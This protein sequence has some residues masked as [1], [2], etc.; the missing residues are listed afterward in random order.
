MIYF[1]FLQQKKAPSPIIFISI[2]SET[3]RKFQQHAN[4]Q[5]GILSKY[6]GKSTYS[7]ESH[8]ENTES[9]Q[10]STFEGILIYFID[11]QLWKAFFLIEIMEFGSSRVSK[12]RQLEKASI[13]IILTLEGIDIDLRFLFSPNAISHIISVPSLIL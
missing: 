11:L 6:L 3:F 4:I 13:P 10:Y 5:L 7:K 1:K 12:F 8:P 9:S 2:G